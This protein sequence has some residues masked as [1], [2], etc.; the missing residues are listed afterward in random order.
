MPGEE[1]SE[2][3]NYQFDEWGIGITK[4]DHKRFGFASFDPLSEANGLALSAVRKKSNQLILCKG[5]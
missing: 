4:R 1:I 3:S 2:T 5:A